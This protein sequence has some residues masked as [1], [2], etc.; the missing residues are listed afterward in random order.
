MPRGKKKQALYGE[1]E[2]EENTKPQS[3]KKNPAA[4]DDDAADEDLDGS[5]DGKQEEDGDAPAEGDSSKGLSKKDIKK[6]KKLKRQGKLTEEELQHEA[7][8][9]KDRYVV[10][11]PP[12]MI[13]HA[14]GY[15]WSHCGIFSAASHTNPVLPV[16][17]PFLLP[18]ASPSSLVLVLVLLLLLSHHTL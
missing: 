15:R 10:L 11:V 14:T 4:E 16:S 2:E 17:L 8:Q 5:N 1:D 3:T 13:L 6:L 9:V 18:L 12:Q 7:L